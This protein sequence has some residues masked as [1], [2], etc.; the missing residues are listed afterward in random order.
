MKRNGVGCKMNSWWNKWKG[1]F[2][3]NI[4]RIFLGNTYELTFVYES[5]DDNRYLRKYKTMF[6]TEYHDD[7]ILYITGFIR[8]QYKCVIYLLSSDNLYITANN[9][10]QSLDAC[11]RLKR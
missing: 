5:N 3:G 8:K 4:S 7:T 2:C 10:L 6:T 11:C 9:L 1:Y